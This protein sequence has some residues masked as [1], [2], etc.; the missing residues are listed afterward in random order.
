MLSWNAL[1]SRLCVTGLVAEAMVVSHFSLYSNKGTEGI[2]G[3]SACRATSE[4]EKVG[5]RALTPV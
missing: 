3:W 1:D 2:P 5:K 4:E